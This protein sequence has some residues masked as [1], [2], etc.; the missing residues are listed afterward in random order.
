MN[1]LLS[2]TDYQTVLANHVLTNSNFVFNPRPS[3]YVKQGTM[4]ILKRTTDHVYSGLQVSKFRFFDREYGST[5]A[6]TSK[7]LV[8]TKGYAEIFSEDV[9][10]VLRD[11]IISALE[12]VTGKRDIF[13]PESNVVFRLNG[14][15]SCL[16]G[17]IANK[18]NPHSLCSEAK[19][20]FESLENVKICNKNTMM[21]PCLYDNLVH[22]HGEFK[23]LKIFYDS[24]LGKYNVCNQDAGKFILTSTIS[25]SVEENFYSSFSN[26]MTGILDLKIVGVYIKDMNTTSDTIK[27]WAN[28]VESNLLTPFSEKAESF[29][30]MADVEE[31]YEDEGNDTTPLIPL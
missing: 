20:V 31:E 26:T 7:Q 12:K 22:S 14:L 25:P 2:V 29:Y 6:S 17:N 1:N 30:H 23:N 24:R 10:A 28:L 27:I 19:G 16:G 9:K 5:A 11:K 13:L 8:Y 4:F 15:S 18:T 21:I 3:I